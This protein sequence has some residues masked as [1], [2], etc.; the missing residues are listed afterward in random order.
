MGRLSIIIPSRDERFLIPTIDDIFRNARGETEVIAV[1]DSD[2]WPGDWKEVVARHAP[3]LH[4]IFHGQSFGM[5]RAINNG[6]ASAISRGAKYV[7]KFDGHCSFGEGFD[8]ILKAECDAD[9]VVVPRR[10]RLEPESW[11]IAEPDKFPHDYHYLSFPN[12]PNDFG[13]GGLNGKPWPERTKARAEILVDEEMSSQGSG[14]FMHADYYQRLELMDEAS[15]GPFWNEFQEIGLK[16]W[17]SGGK[18]MVNKKTYYAHLH[19]G[20]KYGRGYKLDEKWLTMGRNHT[21]KWIHNEAWDKQTLPFSWLIEHFA[22]VPTWPENWEEILYATR[23]PRA[24]VGVGAVRVLPPEPAAGGE[25]MLYGIDVGRAESKSVLHDGQGNRI[26]GLTIIQAHYGIG[27]LE[28]IDVRER[29]QNL[30]FLNNDSLD[31]I[32]N[33]STLTPGQNPFRGQKKQL[34]VTY[35]YD[36]GEVVTV[37]RAEK[38]WLIIGNPQKVVAEAE[39]FIANTYEKVKLMRKDQALAG[40]DPEAEYDTVMGEKQNLKDPTTG[41]LITSLSQLPPMSAPALNDYLIRKFHISPQRLRGPMPIELRD[42]HRNDLAQLFAE[43]GFKRGA[44]I[45]VAE[46]HYSEILCKAIPDLEL[47]CIDPW[48]RYSE[49]PQ[50]HSKEHHEFS[51]NETNRRLELFPKARMVQAYSMDAVRDVAPSYLDFCYIDGNHRFDFVIQDIIEWSKRVR[52]GGIV[53]G[54]DYYQ[55]NAK[56]NDGGVVEAV[57]AYTNAHRIPIWYIFEG[58]KSTDFMWVRP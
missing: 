8:E 50:N 23:K 28:D 25:T 51:F 18:V 42:F 32:V 53:S 19:K 14:W 45:G 7:A 21:M 20:R 33:N 24:V 43:L 12:D 10:L 56:W 6:V 34:N 1:L 31:I 40:V 13:G 29:L 49:N 58:H 44:E 22:P 37:T 46:G 35:S 54:D 16:C 26:P 41:P 11:T 15:Y 4:T 17:L 39:Q 5:R 9:W 3:N 55:L 48:H 47:L 30:A 57:Q 36:G 38:E 52:S 2:K 27:G